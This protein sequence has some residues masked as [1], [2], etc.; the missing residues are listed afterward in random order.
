MKYV[1]ADT[2]SYW[3]PVTIRRPDP[4]NAGKIVEQTFKVRLIPKGQDA[5][6]EEEEAIRSKPNLR[7]Q[8]KAEREALADKVDGWDVT[9]ANGQEV[10]FSR[11]RL[12]DELQ[13]SWFRIGLYNAIAQSAAGEEARLGN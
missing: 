10:P 6:L 2:S 9:D 13:N 8:A 4:E 12:L 5:L 11:E 7:A 3:W 1:L